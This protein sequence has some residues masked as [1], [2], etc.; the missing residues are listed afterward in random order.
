MTGRPFIE[1]GDKSPPLDFAVT[2]L[3]KAFKDN[4]AAAAVE[5]AALYSRPDPQWPCNAGEQG[6]SLYVNDKRII[7]AG[8]D[9]AGAMYGGLDLAALFSAG[10]DLAGLKSYT[11]TPFVLRRGIK[12]NLPLDARTPSYSDSGDSAQEN[13]VNVWDMDFWKGFL[14]RMARNKFNVLSLWNLSPFPSMVRIPRYPETSLADVKRAVRMPRGTLR[15]MDFFTGQQESSLVTIKKMTIEEKIIFWRNVMEY[16]AERCVGVYLF[17]WNIYTYGTQYSNY[18]ISDSPANPVTRDY[19]RR[20]TEALIRTYPLLKG[21]GVTAGEN[22]RREWKTDVREDLVWVRETYGQ[23]VMDAL[24]REKD[25]PFTLIFRS[26]MTGAAQMEE[27]FKDFPHTFEM[28]FKYSMAHIHSTEKPRFGDKF[29]SEMNR[30][31]KA[32]L[33]LRD[34]DFYLLR[35]ADADFVRT[36]LR[37]LPHAVLGGFYLG[38]D[39]IIWGRDY[40]VRDEG[41]NGAYFFDRHKLSFSLWGELAYSIEREEGLFRFSFAKDFGLGGEMAYEALKT[42]SRAIPIQQCVYWHDYDF[43]WYP[44][45]SASYL[46]GEDLLIFH[47]VLDFTQGPACPD[48]GYLSIG[49]YCDCVS[50]GEAPQ[51]ITPPEAAERIEQYCRAALSLLQSAEGQSVNSKSAVTGRSFAAKNLLEDIRA[52]AYL[53]LYYAYKIRAA[54]A[55]LLCRQAARPQDAKNRRREAIANARE[56]AACW[57]VYSS[58]VAARYRPQR[59]DRLRNAVSPDMFDGAVCFDITI[60]ENL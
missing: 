11:V 43:Q 53:G 14:D 12:F 19:V 17:T 21:I 37:N 4:P 44:E 20:G 54:T 29:F 32:W 38:S 6:Y 60:C 5:K 52:M 7:I 22:F 46:E 18:G 28:S 9:A 51:G 33:T 1:V 35:W 26:H 58:S 41:E 59:L 39:G 3:E 57:K 49:D 47:S 23:G 24:I 16:A 56:A 40:A 45:A 48:S 27:V 8:A 42:A 2:E 50:R 25:R 15:G 31:R 36:Y 55:V 30:E 34:D 10:G 13:I